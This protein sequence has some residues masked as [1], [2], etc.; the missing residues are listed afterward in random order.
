MA[1]CGNRVAASRQG[2]RDPPVESLLADPVLTGEQA[3]AVLSDERVQT[4]HRAVPLYRCQESVQRRERF[5]SQAGVGGFENLVRQIHVDPVEDRQVEKQG[6]VP[7]RQTAQQPRVEKVSG[8]RFAPLD[9]L[10]RVGG[11]DAAI[12]AQSHRPPGRALDDVRQLAP[13]QTATEEPGDLRFRE[14]ELFGGH[15]HPRAIENDAR[16]IQPRI[17]AERQGEM[18]IARTAPQ[19]AIEQLNRSARQ[20][21]E[22]VQHKQARSRMRLDRANEHPDLMRERGCGPGVLVALRRQVQSRA[23]ERVREMGSEQARRVV[24]V[25]REPGDEHTPLLR[26]PTD[27]GERGGLAESSGRSQHR[28]PP[29]RYRIELPDQCGP[30]EVPVRRFGRRHLR[31]QQP[32]C[33]GLGDR[34]LHPDILGGAHSGIVCLPGVGG[35]RRRCGCG[36]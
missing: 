8:E 32:G 28:N 4:P 12:D 7:V 24:L 9:A 36:A 30:M 6:A 13:R 21:L 35:P 15:H 19:Q 14:A 25:H 34:T 33:A 3:D 5:G 31:R 22:F 10:D 11:P 27:F 16:Q 2:F 18:E 1:P 20:L 23:L 26:A 17:G 29:V